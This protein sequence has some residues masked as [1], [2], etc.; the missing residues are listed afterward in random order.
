MQ[1]K[2]NRQKNNKAFRTHVFQSHKYRTSI[3]VLLCILY[4]YGSS[5]NSRNLNPV[6]ADI[7]HKSFHEMLAELTMSV[8]CVPEMA[9]IFNKK[10]LHKTQN[11]RAF[12]EM[13]FFAKPFANGCCCNYS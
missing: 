6:S 8:C 11:F 2:E 10:M 1:K 4:I 12:R 7:L 9:Y 5:C 3:Y 13:K